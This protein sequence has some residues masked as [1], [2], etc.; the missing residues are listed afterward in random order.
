MALQQRESEVLSPAEAGDMADSAAS[1][2]AE[3]HI[4]ALSVTQSLFYGTGGIAGGLVFTMMNN[5]LPL[6]LLSYT[7]PLGLPAFLNPGGPIPATVVALLTNERSFFGGLVQPLVGHWSDRTTSRIGRRSPYVLVGGIVTAIAITSLA[8]QPPFWLMLAAVTLAGISLFV[9]VGPYTTLLAD[10]T[11]YRQRGRIGGMIALAG[12][13]GALTFTLLSVFLWE[14]ARGWVFAITGAGVLASM[15]IVAFGVR[16]PETLASHATHEGERPA[17]LWHEILAYRPLALY[18]GAMGVYWLGAGAATPFI[19]RFGVVE[20]NIPEADSFTLLLVIVLATAVGVIASGFLADRIGK[21]RVLLPGLAIFALAAFIGSQARTIE[22]AIPI[23]LLVG[24]GNAAPT[25]L[26][27]PLLADLVPKLRAG[28]CMGFASMVWSVAQPIGSFL[29]GL[30]IDF[31]G[32]YRGVFIF[33]GICML[34]SALVLRYVK[35]E[36]ERV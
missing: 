30:L 3:D 8:F 23:M 16:E 20:L 18:V 15:L 32:S 5:A 27:L 26:H 35:I 14:N 9:A 12:M 19:T 28:A 10:I 33:A 6:F 24:I 1:G 36:G 11:P 29:G 34:A 4:A 25:A 2:E 13:I 21:K 22:Q 7:M 17:K 31:T